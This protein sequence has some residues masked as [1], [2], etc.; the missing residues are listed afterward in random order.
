[1]ED[2][3]YNNEEWGNPPPNNQPWLSRDALEIPGR[4]H[5]L[6]QHPKKL[7]PKF[8]PETSRFLEDHVKKFIL[9][10]RLVNI[11]HE[12]IVCRIFSYTFENSS[13]TCV[14]SHSG[15]LTK[16]IL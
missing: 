4:V 16:L 12:D 3:N 8:N 9:S 1:M 11:Q 6:P 10:I 2:N 7:L 5:N 15:A 13:S 14:T